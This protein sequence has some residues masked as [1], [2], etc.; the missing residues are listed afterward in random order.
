MGSVTS[1]DVSGKLNIINQ[2]DIEDEVFEDAIDAPKEANINDTKRPHPK[3]RKINYPTSSTDQSATSSSSSEKQSEHSAE[4]KTT[5]A[6]TSNGQ[7][8]SSWTTTEFSDENE[9]PKAGRVSTFSFK[10]IMLFGAWVAV[11]VRHIVFA[12][13][14]LGSIPVSGC[15]GD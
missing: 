5:K 2:S 14:V 15:C 4:T 10:K 13:E 3:P 6:T 1:Y 8:L 7:N 11:G 9:K 12:R